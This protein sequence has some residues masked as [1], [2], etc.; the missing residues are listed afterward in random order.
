MTYGHSKVCQN[1]HSYAKTGIVEGR[2]LGVLANIGRRLW[3]AQ[4]LDE[5]ESSRR[6]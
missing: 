1:R 3:T 6:E 2:A 5:W 4:V